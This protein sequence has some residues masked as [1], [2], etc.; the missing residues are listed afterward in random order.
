MTENG[1]NLEAEI[2]EAAYFE[3]K[4]NGTLPMDAWLKAEDDILRWEGNG[5]RI[6][7]RRRDWIRTRAYYLS[8]EGGS[9]LQ[10]WIEA[11]CQYDGGRKPI[12]DTIPLNG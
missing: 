11:E 7:K 5:Y 4:N 1:R 2:K 12:Y 3:S 8:L 9:P 6:L 10:N